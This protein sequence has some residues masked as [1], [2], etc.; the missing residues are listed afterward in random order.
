MK[1]NKPETK[2]KID[3]S[4]FAPRRNLSVPNLLSALRI[5]L[6]PAIFAAYFRGSRC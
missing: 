3:L 6:I 2:Q 5:L 4:Q 1:Q